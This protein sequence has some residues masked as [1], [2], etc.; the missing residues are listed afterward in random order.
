[1]PPD[2]LEFAGVSVKIFYLI[3]D[4]ATGTGIVILHI[5]TTYFHQ[6]HELRSILVAGLQLI[7]DTYNGSFQTLH[8]L[9]KGFLRRKINRFQVYKITTA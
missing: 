7:I 6:S 5:V 2:K 8:I 1:M 9:I 3:S 4:A